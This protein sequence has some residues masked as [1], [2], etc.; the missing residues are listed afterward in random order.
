MLMNDQ[1]I[2]KLYWTRSEQAIAVPAEKYGK[3]CYSIAFQILNDHEDAMECVNDTYLR[4]WNSMPPNRPDSLS[5]YLGKI[6]RNL[7]RNRYK[8]ERTKKRGGSQTALALEELE[9]C[10]AG[11]G[12][13]ADSMEMQALGGLINS[14]LFDQTERNRNIFLRRYWM[15]SPIKDI[16]DFY[17]ISE[18]KVKS[19]L[20]RMRKK[21][22][23]L[24]KDEEFY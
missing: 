16:A 13:P 11:G 20:F 18:S 17:G 6:T 23:K 1:D 5:A 4:A 14:F 12:D 7:A 19:I 10:I 24:L 2:I 15:L 21:L 9:M 22:A 3:Y 8:L